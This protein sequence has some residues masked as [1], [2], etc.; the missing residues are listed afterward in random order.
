MAQKIHF[1]PLESDPSIF[2]GLIHALGVRRLEFQDVLSLELAD[3]VPT[4]SL[5]LP[6]PIYAL[7]LVFPVTE[8][9]EAE[10]AAAKSRAH[11]EGTQYAGRGPEEPVIWF[12]QTIHN[13]C[14]LYAILHAASNLEPEFIDPESP[15]GD[16]LGACIDFDP[17]GRA[18]ALEASATIAAAHL[19]AATQGATPV[20]NAEDEVNFHYVCFVKS[21]L[22]GHLYE[23]DGDRNGPVDHDASLEGDRDLLSGGLKLVKSYLQNGNPQYQLMALVPRCDN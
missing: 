20:P 21:P 12:Q 6:G 18:A 15:L 1:I 5:A 16:L 10:L 13:A 22:N 11:L 3:L 19:Q 9:Y 8:T 14:G 4:G 23:M 7:I 17:T 2:T